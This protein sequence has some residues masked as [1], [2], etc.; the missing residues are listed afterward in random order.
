MYFDTLGLL[1]PSITT[2]SLT[3]RSVT[4]SWTQPPFSFNPV[5]YTVTLTRV[6]GSDQV[7]CPGVKDSRAP[8]TTAAT[9]WTF[10]LL[11]EFSTYHVEVIARFMEF[12]LSVTVPAEITFTTLSAG[13]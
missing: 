4:V 3:A 5:S 6:T 12:S 13:T 2:S 9:S 10:T 11:E 1:A 7:L 8:I